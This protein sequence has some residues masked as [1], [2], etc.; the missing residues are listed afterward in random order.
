MRA[1]HYGH[2]QICNR[3]Q[4]LPGGKLAKHGYELSHGFMNGVCYGAESLPFEQST[5]LIEGSIARAI[6]YAAELRAKAE[7]LRQIT[8]S[9]STWRKVYHREL[10]SRSRG[11]VYLWTEGQI[12]GDSFKAEFVSTTG[13]REQIHL[14]GSGLSMAREGRQDYAAALEARAQEQDRYVEQQRLRLAGW[15]PRELTPRGAK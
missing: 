8:D 15:E 6:A 4:L 7:A 1:T 9:R 11:S 3:R 14:P 13:K 10:S 12:E 2:C 5:N